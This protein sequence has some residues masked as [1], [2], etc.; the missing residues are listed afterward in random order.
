[1]SE[2]RRLAI[3]TATAVALAAG[4]GPRLGS[5]Q[6]RPV[7]RPNNVPADPVSDPPE[8]GAIGGDAAKA[9]A[10]LD[11]NVV[12]AQAPGGDGGFFFPRAEMLPEG[13]HAVGLTVDAQAPRAINLNKSATLWI[14]V[15]NSGTTEALGVGVREQLPDGLEF[16]ESTPAPASKTPFLFWDLK[17]VPA[18]KEQRIKLIVKATKKLGSI[19]HA[20]M[21]TMMTGGRARMVIREPKLRVEQR[22]STSQALKG[23]P[24]R[25]D[26]TITN[27][28][29]GPARDVKVTAK[30]G[31]GLRF[32]NGGQVV[33]K[34]ADLEPS[35]PVLAA[36]ESVT[37][38]PL[39]VEAIAEGDNDCTV[40]AESPD[41]APGAPEAQAVDP[42]KVV[43]P[44][45][46]LTIKGHTKRPTGLPETY[47]VIVENTG[48]AVAKNVRAAAHVER[49]ARLLNVPDG[50]VWKKDSQSLFWELGDVDPKKPVDLPFTVVLD[51]VQRYSF[52][53][54]TQ[55]DGMTREEKSHTTDVVGMA[56]VSLKVSEKTR[57]IDV[58]ESTEFSVK[59]VNK[60][61]SEARNLIISANLTDNLAATATGGTEPAGQINPTTHAVQFPMIPNLA[62]GAVLDLTIQV[63]ALKPGFGKCTVEIRHDDLPPDGKEDDSE[64]I[65]VIDAAP[66]AP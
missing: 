17:T 9:P 23:E 49:G 22:A 58:G 12:P 26:I 64:S 4:I 27:T 45:L 52:R 1:M 66:P 24:I 39:M 19:D 15:K 10:K 32:E 62:V 36:N 55:G 34:L 13:M 16:V 60:G 35:K 25:F 11:V 59:V 40:V 31:P 57:A 46:A 56:D 18:G 5:A 8:P 2:V 47:H 7:A 20:P 43:A 38:D 42:V 61:S 63:K 28:G 41:V 44:K 30:L 29:D 3:V 54:A 6:D 53:A 51:G 21:V 14:I 50:A 37:L 65:R 48:S 33:L